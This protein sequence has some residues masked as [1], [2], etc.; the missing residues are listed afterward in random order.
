MMMFLAACSPK[1][2]PVQKTTTVDPPPAAT[3]TQEE[4]KTSSAI[5]APVQQETEQ[6]EIVISLVLPFD[7][8]SVNLSTSNLRDLSKSE[9]PID[10]YQGFKMGIDSVVNSIGGKFKLQVYD[11]KDSPAAAAALA[12]KAGVKNSDL[13]VGPV[14]P[15]GIK[16]FSIHSKAMRKLMVSPLAATAPETFNNPYLI[17]VNNSLEQHVNKG[18]DFIK[19]SLKP[20]H[21]LLIRSGQE[22]EHRYA[23]PFKAGINNSSFSF[24]E[25]GIKAVGFENIFKHLNQTGKNVVVLPSTDRNFLLSVT[26]ELEKLAKQFHITVIGHPGWDKLQ[27]LDGNTMQNI[28]AHITSSSKIDYKSVRTES[29]IKNYRERFS[30]E[31]GEFAFKGF[32]IGFYFAKIMA[33]KGKDFTEDISRTKYEGLHNNIRFVKN[34]YGY[35]NSEL[36]V[37]K[38]EDFQLKRVD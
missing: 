5:Q 27:F 8:S 19:S 23:V 31:P 37:L 20:K 11:S 29:F 16:A 13:I 12:S 32:D 14:F 33:A 36:L 9:L 17:T 26:K 30:L 38:Y 21:V 28:N 22:D 3:P 6:P 2:L 4:H 7:L 18:L 15:N 10:F 1:T 35:Y 25:I 24:S 34:E